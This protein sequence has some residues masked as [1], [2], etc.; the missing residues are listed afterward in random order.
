MAVLNV[1]PLDLSF[2][3]LGP[4]IVEFIQER[5]VFGPGSLAGQPAKLDDETIAFIYRLYE[6]MPKGH[7]LAGRRRFSR[8]ALELRKGLAKTE[9]AAWIAYCELHPEA[10]VRCDGFDANGNPVGRPVAFPYIPMMAVTE[11]QVSE[12]AYGVLKYVVEEGPDADLFDSSLERIMRLNDRGRGD[13]QAVPV[14]NAPGSR[15]G[16]LTTFQHFDE[17]HRLYLPSAKHAH[18]T[19]SANL[20]KR[21]LEDPWALYTSTAG[22]P[23]QN[24]IQEDVRAEAE[25]IARK[26]IEEPALMFFARWAGDEHKDLSTIE[27]RVAA[28]ADATGPAGEYG[29]GQFESIA[30]QWDRPKADKAY[31]E[32]VWLNRWRKSDSTF[33]DR[34]KIG[35]LASPG[36]TIPAGAFVTLGFDGARFRDA[37]AMVATEVA[38]GLQEL[39]GLWERP[40]DADEWEVPEDEVTATFKD[41]MRRYRVWKLYADPPHWTETIGSWYADYP[42]HVEEWYT[43]RHGQMAYVLREYQ[44]A[45]DAGTIRFGGRSNP[46]A[47]IGKTVSPHDDLVRHLGNAG[48]KELRL[49]DD[50]GEPLYVMQKQD[51]QMGLKFDAAMAAVLSWKAR[52]DALKGNAKPVLKRRA[53]IRRIGG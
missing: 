12:L 43:K 35:G 27:Q 30:K 49:R 20:T 10:P 3:T 40:D 52:L 39:I 25:A 15:D 6:V 34:V 5:A 19:M 14:S 45:I 16:A 26:E 13:G 51:G 53:V 42:G 1:P 48:K 23:G 50:A 44:E 37:T 24:S 36:E 31:L 33:F 17:P 21:A 41:A 32:R 29:P 38:T 11:E 8:G 2:P 7:R 22:A 9:K 28:I 47:V 4:G 18:E 46:D